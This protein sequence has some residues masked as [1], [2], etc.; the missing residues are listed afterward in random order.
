VA[1][2]S[3]NGASGGREGGEATTFGE[4]KMTRSW[5]DRWFGYT[6]EDK[7]RTAHLVGLVLA[8]PVIISAFVIY[9]G[10]SH[11]LLRRR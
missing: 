5:A 9:I 3:N 8:M 1:E 4:S 10:V 7:V 11:G 6:R 2:H